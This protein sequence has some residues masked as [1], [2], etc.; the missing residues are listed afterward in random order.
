DRCIKSLC[1]LSV[2]YKLFLFFKKTV[3]QKLRF[4]TV[5]GALGVVSPSLAHLASLRFQD[6]CIKPL[7]H[8]S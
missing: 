4:S 6:R 2:E 5:C 3:F 1:H 8:L 7:C